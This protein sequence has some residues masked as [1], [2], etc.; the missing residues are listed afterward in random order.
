MGSFSWPR[1]LVAKVG[2]KLD[3]LAATLA[4][5]KTRRTQ[6]QRFWHKFREVMA[7]FCQQHAFA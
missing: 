5:G 1:T 2:Q 6:E 7:L 3:D 4:R